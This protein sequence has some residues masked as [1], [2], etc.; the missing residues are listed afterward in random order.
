M[1][2]SQELIVDITQ[3]E[4]QEPQE[5][6]SAIGNSMAPASAPC[7][8]CGTT[9]PPLDNGQCSN[10]KCRSLRANHTRNRKTPDVDRSRVKELAAKL[11][12]DFKPTT[13]SLITTCEQLAT[14]TERLEKV[15]P[16]S[17]EHQRLFAMWQ[18]LTDRLETSRPEPAG[19][20]GKGGN[21]VIFKLPDNNRE[22]ENVCDETALR[23]LRGEP[24]PTH[25]PDVARS[26]REASPTAKQAASAAGDFKPPLVPERIVSGEGVTLR[27]ETKMREVREDEVTSCLDASG[28]LP[29]YRS[30]AISRERAYRITANWLR[31][32]WDDREL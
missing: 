27:I 10:P 2:E 23:E 22:A 25:T 32:Q 17:V 30:G 26:A 1:S 16:G 20:S 12:A 6:I 4:S 3:A 9:D 11:K 24:A 29:A 31:Q 13:Q 15:K 14:V 5:P 19:A 28:D 18:N 7:K 21:V 8:R